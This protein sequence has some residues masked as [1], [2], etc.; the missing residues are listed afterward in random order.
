[1]TTDRSPGHD[2]RHERM[3]A[4]LLGARE[5]EVT[6]TERAELEACAVCAREIADAARFAREIGLVGARERA[7]LERARTI[8]GAPSV[9]RAE[10]LARAD[11]APRRAPPFLWIAV[12]ASIAALVTAVALRQRER[13]AP[14]PEPTL[15]GDA[16][17]IEVLTPRGDSAGFALFEWR[18]APLREG[19][20]FVVTVYDGRDGA[21]GADAV[22]EV[23]TSETSWRPPNERTDAWPDRITWQ[24]VAYDALG[25]RS[26]SSP[27]VPASRSR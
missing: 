7:D 2:A 6:Q 5:G 1:M 18:Y 16:R 13:P 25:K 14:G 8:Q 19:E 23:R 11:L 3:L 9:A 4:V 27:L 17:A 22:A 24:V 20:R 26:A 21:L 12:A 15:S 10:A